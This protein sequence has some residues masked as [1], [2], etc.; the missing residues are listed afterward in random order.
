M[1]GLQTLNMTSNQI[2]L[3]GCNLVNKLLRL[4][5]RGFFAAAT[6]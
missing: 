1:L 3:F 5:D 6:D 2:F 4:D